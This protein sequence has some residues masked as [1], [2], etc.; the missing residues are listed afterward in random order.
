MYSEFINAFEEHAAI[1]E[2]M[3]QSRRKLGEIR[4]KAAEYD[5]LDNKRLCVFAAGSLGRL[6]SG[7]N[8]DFDVFML[9]YDPSRRK[10]DL[11]SV[12]RL[13]EY[14]VFSSLIQINQEL[15]FP[16]FSGDGRFLKTYEVYEM[17]KATGSPQDDSENLFTARMLLLLESQPI[18]NEELYSSGIEEVIS[19]Y[20]RDGRG[21]NDFRPLFLLNDILRY[22]RT[23]CLNYEVYR[24]DTE[25]PWFK[26]NLNLKFSRKLTIFSTVFAIMAELANDQ[27]SFN[28][29]CN[30][31]PLERLAK[32]LDAIEDPSLLAGFKQFLNDYEVFLRGKDKSMVAEDAP[33]VTK[34][35]YIE[36]AKRFDNFLHSVIDSH[37]IDGVIRRYVLI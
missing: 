14:E 31:T 20:Y 5:S 10:K 1:Q 18:T 35:R 17:I 12:T 26:K 33:K 21:R 24:G 9:A 29:L 36:A 32:A 15:S 8:S 4:T 7:K 16:K 27:I 25:R 11:N 2:R 30:L 34:R 3:Q 19:N 28:Q 6:E 22:W 37:R 23:L 13:E